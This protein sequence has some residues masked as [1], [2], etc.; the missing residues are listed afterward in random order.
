MVPLTMGAMR[1]KRNKASSV[2]NL[3]ST[4]IAPFFGFSV[5]PAQNDEFLVTNG[6]CDKLCAKNT[7][8]NEDGASQKAC[9]ARIMGKVSL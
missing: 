9:S 6:M 5:N 4:S 1:E 7:P 2:F 8:S 3:S